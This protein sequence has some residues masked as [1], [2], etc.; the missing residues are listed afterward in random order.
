L[1]EREDHDARMAALWIMHG[2]A[3]VKLL[4]AHGR[5][6]HAENFEAALREFVDIIAD[7]VGR[8]NLSAA[9]DWAATQVSLYGNDLDRRDPVSIH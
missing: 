8:D 5:M 2:T 7:E 6:I 3:C 4:K 1:I 9:M